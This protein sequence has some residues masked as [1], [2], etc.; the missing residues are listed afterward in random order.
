MKRLSRIGAIMMSAAFVLTGTGVADAQSR[1]FW[2][3]D[4]SDRK[5]DVDWIS[6][7]V[8]IVVNDNGIVQVIDG[9]LI[10]FEQSPKTGRVMRN[11][12][13]ILSVRWQVSNAR[14]ASN[15]TIPDF[16]YD[17]RLNKE[18]GRVV[19]GAKP[20]GFGNKFSGRGT[21]EIRTE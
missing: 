2:A 21:C 20:H 6:P 16:G 13:K 11:T 7:T 1:T 18:T 8:G 10:A 5:K 17:L 14:D 12:D 4:I 3:C 9:V 15:Q 19:I